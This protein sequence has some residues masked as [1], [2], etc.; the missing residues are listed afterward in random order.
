VATNRIVGTHCPL[1]GDHD[2]VR[3]VTP[4]NYERGRTHTAPAS[5]EATVYVACRSRFSRARSYLR[6]VRGSAWPAASWTS[7]NMGHQRPK[8]L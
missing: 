4:G 2:G 6:V 7:R 5:H 3:V 1:R 8:Q